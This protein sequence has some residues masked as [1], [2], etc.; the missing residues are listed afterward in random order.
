MNTAE[1][2]N[3]NAVCWCGGSVCV[4]VCMDVCALACA[5]ACV[6]LVLCVGV[7]VCVYVCVHAPKTDE[8]QV[9]LR[10]GQLA[11]EPREKVQLQSS[12]LFLLT[13]RSW[14]FDLYRH[15]V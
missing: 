15:R 1:W 9:E 2:I 12:A 10:S 13:G 7:C 8:R 14:C 6:C 4:C 11:A 3:I 5:C